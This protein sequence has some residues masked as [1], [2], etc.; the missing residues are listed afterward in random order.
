M[1]GQL[2]FA[3]LE[4]DQLLLLGLRLLLL[5]R[6]ELGPLDRGLPAALVGADAGLPSGGGLLVRVIAGGS[7]RVGSQAGVLGGSMARDH[8]DLNIF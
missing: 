4:V 3:L 8:L 1:H 5:A 2:G 7:L 6:G